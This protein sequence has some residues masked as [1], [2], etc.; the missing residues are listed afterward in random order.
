MAFHA[1]EL[2]IQERVGVREMAEDVGS[3][4][5][6]AIS[7][8]VAEF[9]KRRQFAILGSV[10]SDHR[11]SASVVTGEPSFIK[12]LEPRVLKLESLPPP[13]DPL[14]ANL[15]TESHTALIAIDLLKA[16][17][18]RINGKAILG[19]GAIWITTEQVYANCPRYIQERLVVN[20]EPKERGEKAEITRSTSLMRAQRDQIVSAD[21]FFIASDHPGSGA[22][23]SHKGGSPGFVH[24]VDEHHLAIPD[25]NGNRMFN[26]LGNILVNPKAGLLFIDFESGR[27]LQISGIASIDFDSKRAHEFTGAERILDFQ[28]E[29]IIDNSAGFPLSAKFRQ[30]SRYNP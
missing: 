2:E 21:T 27:T 26:T 4:I 17:R 5:I 30:F 10:D 16:R 3:G 15:V 18:V 29:T 20:A 23:V 14:L 6:D 11:A 22:D 19:K 25:Y 12:V 13:G 1:G 28:I 9:L 24:V 7:G 8:T